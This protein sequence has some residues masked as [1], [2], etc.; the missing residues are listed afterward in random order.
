[1]NSDEQF[2]VY[3]CE[4]VGDCVFVCSIDPLDPGVACTC[5]TCSFGCD[6][7]DAVLPITSA[8]Y[9]MIEND[10]EDPNTLV[11]GPEVDAIRVTVPVCGDGITEGP[12]ECDDGNTASGDG[13]SETCTIEPEDLDGDGV[14]DDVDNCP[15]SDLDS[16]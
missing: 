4:T 5:Q 16:S 8:N 9:I 6:L 1:L 2:N 15:N 11:E 13:C 7:A 12:E 10:R 3:A 14:P